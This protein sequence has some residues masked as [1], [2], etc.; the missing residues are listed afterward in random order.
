MTVVQLCLILCDPWMVARQATL[1]M[2]FSRQ[3]YW[4]GYPFPSSGDLP[5]LGTK[6]RSPSLQA[7]FFLPPEQPGE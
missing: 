2:E 1:S 3:E 5:D 7:Y 4:S 6:H